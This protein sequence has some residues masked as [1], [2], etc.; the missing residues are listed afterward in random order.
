MRIGIDARL[1]G[2]QHTGI[3]RYT[4]NLIHHL[5]LLDKK[6]TYVIFSSSSNQPDF[7]SYSNVEFVPLDTKIYSLA[8]QL[9]NPL[10]FLK[11]H[12]DLLHV[13]HFNAPVFYP[14]KLIITVHDLIKHLSLGPQ[15][16]TLPRY[17][18]FLKHLGYRLVLFSNLHRSQAV[19]TPTQYW[20]DYLLDHY[21][22]SPQKVHVTLEAADPLLTQPDS[23]FNP[24]KQFQLH[25]PFVVYTGNLYPH[26]NVNLLTSAIKKYNQ[27]YKTKLS[28]AVVGARPVFKKSLKTSKHIRFLGYLTD[29]QLSSLYKKAVA[30]V[31]PSLIEG[32]GLTGL[33]AMSVDLPVLSSNATCLPEVYSDAAIYF[34]PHSVS[35]LTQKLRQIVTKT[36][37]RSH[38]IKKGQA[39]FKQFSWQKTAQ[40]THKLYEQV[41][42]Q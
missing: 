28:L 19:I 30:L 40:L 8:E 42:H 21:H 24:Q 11:A 10:V 38:L 15:T 17:Q 14:K 25:S 32:F 9:I 12:L 37:L 20:R 18:Y 33:E 34:D 7:S 3:G 13:P 22:L 26:K 27:V 41:L 39:R 35:D 36:T 29:A 31:Q 2:P 5:L 6:N 16:S 1:Y 23:S 4:K